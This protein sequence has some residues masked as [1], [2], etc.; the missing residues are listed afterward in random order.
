MS[1]GID[2]IA[3][4]RHIT[5]NEGEDRFKGICAL[6]GQYRDI[7]EDPEGLMCDKCY[8]KEQAG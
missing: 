5:G 8:G 6:C 4:D 7:T 1:T 2:T 3:L